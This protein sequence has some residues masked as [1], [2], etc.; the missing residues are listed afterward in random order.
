MSR[1]NLALNVWP[2]LV[3]WPVM[4]ADIPIFTDQ[5]HPVRSLP[6]SVSVVEPDAAQRLKNELAAALPT[7]PGVATKAMRRR[8]QQGGEAVVHGM[9]EPD[10]VLR[11]FAHAAGTFEGK[12]VRERGALRLGHAQTAGLVDVDAR[13]CGCN[14]KNAARGQ[15]S[16][17]SQTFAKQPGTTLVCIP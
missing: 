1:S 5:A 4:A 10:R 9:G 2:A 7:D 12:D 14:D 15:G 8:L 16:S 11:R 17:P 13:T 6:S 3:T